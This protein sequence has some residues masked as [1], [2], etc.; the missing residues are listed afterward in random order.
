MQCIGEQNR[1]S[2]T[3]FLFAPSTRDFF[4]NVSE[5]PYQGH[6]ILTSTCTLPKVGSLSAVPI[7]NF[8]GYH[9]RALQHVVLS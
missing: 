1:A 3:S 9:S 6:A 5:G 7:S 2:D 4:Q 8:H